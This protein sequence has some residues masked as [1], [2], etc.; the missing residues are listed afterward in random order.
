MTL[1]DLISSS[2]LGSIVLDFLSESPAFKDVLKNAVPD[3]AADIESSSTNLTCS[4]RTKV[5]AYVTLNNESIGTLLY[6]FANSN[7]VLQNVK[8]LY[9]KALATS[10]SSAVGRVAKTTIADWPTFAKNIYQANMNFNHMST[11]IVGEDVYVFFL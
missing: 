4:C 8:S 11:S 1:E 5:R 7:G 10:K 6:T 9:D 2:F 3:L